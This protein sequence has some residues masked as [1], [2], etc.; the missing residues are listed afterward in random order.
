MNLFFVW[1]YEQD[2][3]TVVDG[4]DAGT[5]GANCIFE[6][7]AGSQIAETLSH[8]IGHFLKCGDHYVAAR[9]YELMYGITDTRGAHIGKVHANIMNR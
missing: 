4:A 9:S 3:L 7:Q 2:A 6:D 5:L 8:E 1:E